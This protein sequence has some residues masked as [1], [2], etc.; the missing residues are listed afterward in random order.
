ME[1]LDDEHAPTLFNMQVEGR[2]FRD[3]VMDRKALA[4]P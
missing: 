4:A 2:T 1:N 3:G